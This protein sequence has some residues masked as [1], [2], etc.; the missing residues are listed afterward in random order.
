MNNSM[1]KKSPD[2]EIVLVINRG[3]KE[4]RGQRTGTRQSVIVI[5]STPTQQKGNSK[6]VKRPMKIKN[7]SNNVSKNV[8]AGKFKE[9]RKPKIKKELKKKKR[10]QGKRKKPKMEPKTQKASPL[11]KK[12]LNKLKEPQKVNSVR[13]FRT[14]D[15][16]VH[17][18][19]T[20]FIQ[21]VRPKKDATNSRFYQL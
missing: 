5:L 15:S 21:K 10:F 20:N 3:S 9:K 17:S 8:L 1:N 2:S 18:H 13:Q 7:K 12:E 11:V 14:N 4:L 16:T 19:V 6:K